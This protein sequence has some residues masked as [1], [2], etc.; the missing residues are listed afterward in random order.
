MCKVTYSTNILCWIQQNPWKWVSLQPCQSPKPI[1]HGSAVLHT[2][3]AKISIYSILFISF[4]L[5]QLLLPE[6]GLAQAPLLAQLEW[7]WQAAAGGGRWVVQDL[8]PPRGRQPLNQGATRC[9]KPRT[10]G[11]SWTNRL[12]PRSFRRLFFTLPEV[13]AR[14]YILK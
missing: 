1:I 2:K 5:T 8:S 7:L 6:T 13:I 4:K 3:L 9:R 14:I 11:W 12:G 10:A